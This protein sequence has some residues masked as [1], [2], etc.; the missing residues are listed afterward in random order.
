MTRAAIKLP[1]LILFVTAATIS[2]S[3]HAADEPGN[4]YPTA[5]RADYVF[6]CMAVNGQSREV[7]QRCACSIDVIA[8][9]LPY[10]QYEQ[11]ETIMSMRQLAGQNASM[12]HSMPQLRE[13]VANL[14]R[15][16]VEAEL[17]CF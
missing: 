5:A 15:A 16:Q 12:F 11:A 10:E 9:L 4:D 14:K 8:T 7:L 2:S 3:V 6:G 13:K 1:A 17:R